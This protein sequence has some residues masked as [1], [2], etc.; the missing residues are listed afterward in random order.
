MDS[1]EIMDR[2][3]TTLREELGR[4]G[5]GSITRVEQALGFSEG[6]LRKARRL[7]SLCLR[8]L[9]RIL[10]HI[11]VDPHTFFDRALRDEPPSDPLRDFGR[12]A[13][14]LARQHPEGLFM[15][16]VDFADLDPLTEEEQQELTDLDNLLYVDIKEVERRASRRCRQ[17]VWASRLSPALRAAGIWSLSLAFQKYVDPA[18]VLLW[19]AIQIAQSHHMRTGFQQAELNDLL[20]RAIHL[21]AFRR[22]FPDALVLAEQTLVRLVVEADYEAIGKFL[23]VRGIMARKLKDHEKCIKSFLSA[24]D[25]LAVR[26]NRN[27]TFSALQCLALEYTTVGDIGKAQHY[28]HR[29]RQHLENTEQLDLSRGP[30]LTG[31]LAWLDAQIAKAQKK[32]YEAEQLYHKACQLL[33]SHPIDQALVYTELIQFLFDTGKPSQARQLAKR[34]VHLTFH[35]EKLPIIDDAVSRLIRAAETDELSLK[36]VQASRAQ[37]ETSCGRSLTL[38]FGDGV[39]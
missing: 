26:K 35:F 38:H 1:Q 18:Q 27:Y 36:L 9:I 25:F 22:R 7:Q 23:T 31:H 2:L 6:Y 19:R 4:A 3:M 5:W 11:E 17:A 16:M 21:M 20:I 29:A 24:L 33:A 30:Y 28:A 39:S 37:I 15:T 32:E 34:L 12:E 10:Q 13:E 14:Q 8:S